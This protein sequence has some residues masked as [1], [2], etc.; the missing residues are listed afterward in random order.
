MTLSNDREKLFSS[1]EVL[2]T[3]QSVEQLISFSGPPHTPSPQH[4]FPGGT[5]SQLGT[6]PPP[7]VEKSP[8]K[9]LEKKGNSS[10]TI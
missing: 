10:V 4:G 8:F 3:T 2:D 7:A 5:S 1:G 9:H 6:H